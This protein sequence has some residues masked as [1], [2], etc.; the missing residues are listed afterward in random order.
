MLSS[1]RCTNL[2]SSPSSSMAV[3]YRSCLLAQKK[4]PDSQ[5]QALVVALRLLHITSTC[6][7]AHRNLFWQLS[8]DRS[9]PDSGMSCTMTKTILRAPWSV[10]KILDAQRE[11]V[12]VHAHARIA[13]SRKDWKRISSELCIMS[14]PKIQPVKGLN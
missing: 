7:M 12:G 6:L 14:P 10:K 5:D 3:K 8:R 1:S 9:S 2:L 4:E 13:Y 11:R